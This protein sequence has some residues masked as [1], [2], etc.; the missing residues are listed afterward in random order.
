VVF[1]PERVID[2]ETF[3]DQAQYS[4]GIPHVMVNGT[5]VV[6]DGELQAGVA[7]ERGLRR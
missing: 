7:P 2:R 3:E 6:K 5:L 1:S 4:V